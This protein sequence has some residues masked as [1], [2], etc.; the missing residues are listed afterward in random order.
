[1]F[2]ALPDAQKD[3]PH[4]NFFANEDQRHDSCGRLSSMHS[5]LMDSEPRRDDSDG[6]ESGED[7][8][9]DWGESRPELDVE[10]EEGVD[11][12]PLDS[13]SFRKLE[14]RSRTNRNSMTATTTRMSQYSLTSSA[15][16]MQ[17]PESLVMLQLQKGYWK[18]KF[19]SIDRSKKRL[20]VVL[21]D[22]TS[23]AK[24][25]CGD[26]LEK[27]AG[28]RHI[29][30]T[31]VAEAARERRRQVRLLEEEKL[32]Q[33]KKKEAEET[34]KKREMAAKAAKEREEKDEADRKALSLL[35][36]P[37]PMK[38][39]TPVKSSQGTP[40]THILTPV[41]FTVLLCQTLVKL[42]AQ[43]EEEREVEDNDTPQMIRA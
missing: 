10:D 30:L 25:G 5:D 41:R 27:T 35:L 37:T 29:D 32:A 6:D 11:V 14:S 2:R 15:W 42:A 18:R 17:S 4:L 1:M 21:N 34:A 33:Q 8:D 19:A 12:D 23:S 31:E 7:A 26:N 9:S 43:A 39:I 40:Y 36:A 20:A 38:S 22:S 24:S 28:S 13:T 16:S 3:F